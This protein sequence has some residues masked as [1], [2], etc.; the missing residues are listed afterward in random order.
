M[1]DPYKEER[2]GTAA[3]G[4]FLI[5]NVPQPVTWLLYGKMSSMPEG[6]G[7]EPVEIKTSQDRQFLDH[8]RLAAG[9]AH[10]VT[11]KVTLSDGRAIAEGMRV[12]LNANHLWDTQTVG[13]RGDGTFEIANVPDGEYCLRPCVRG[14]T[15]R[16]VATS[17]CDVPVK[18]TGGDTRGLAITLYPTKPR[19]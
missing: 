5:S 2:V 11:G 18:V 16:G 15:T 6:E 13:L 9:P 10:I 12:S 17:N 14:Y 3:D 19:P 1:G 8:V 7:T 4:S